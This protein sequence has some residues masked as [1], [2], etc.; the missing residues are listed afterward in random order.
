MRTTKEVK[1]MV[2]KM[3]RN[4]SRSLSMEIEYLIKQEFKSRESENK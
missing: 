3:A 4:D 2:Q 1:Q